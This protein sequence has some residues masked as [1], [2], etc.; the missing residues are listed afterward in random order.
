MGSIRKVS[1]RATMLTK[2]ILICSIPTYLT[3]A[4]M[5]KGHGSAY[6]HCPVGEG[7][8]K[9]NINDGQMKEVSGLAYSRR[10]QEVLWVHNDSGGSTW[11]DAISE[12]GARLADVELQGTTCLDWED[13]AVNKEDGISYIYLA[14]IGDNFYLR[15][16][17]TIYKFKEPEV[18][19]NWTGHDIMIGSQEIEHIHLKYP[20]HA[21]DC[22]AIAVDPFNRDILLFTKNHEHNESKVFKVPNGWDNLKTLE[23]VVTLPYTLVT[24]ADISPSGDTLALTNYGEGW[25]WS[26]PDDQVAWAEFLKTRPTPCSLPL[27][28]EMQR[29]A[30]TFTDSGYWTTSEHQNQPLY[31][32]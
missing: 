14:D 31:Y 8:W 3:N 19:V 28:Q 9:G 24:G 22:E 12:R 11:I 30:I 20:D 2:A 17:L 26:K 18:S 10:S 23:Y 7:E 13:I 25:S 6:Q 1:F 21:Y 15:S 32:Y 29:E 27:K 4:A 16:T 5:I